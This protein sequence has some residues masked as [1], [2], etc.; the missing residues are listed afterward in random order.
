MPTPE[1]ITCPNKCHVWK[2]WSDDEPGWM[3]RI[4]ETDDLFTAYSRPASCI[5]GNPV[6][7]VYC[8]PSRCELHP[9]GVVVATVPL[10]AAMQ[11]A[12]CAMRGE[13][14]DIEGYGDDACR[15]RIRAYLLAKAAEARDEQAHE[16]R[17]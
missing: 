1:T 3:E 11:I 8:V 7:V 12:L 13:Y 9:G 17:A 2:V 14:L 15:S 10:K 6:D 4:D 5:P 16:G